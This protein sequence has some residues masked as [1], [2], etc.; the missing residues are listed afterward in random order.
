MKEIC[1]DA[2]MLDSGGIG[3]YLKRIILGLTSFRLRLLVFPDA[4]IKY[5]WLSPF[6]LLVAPFPIYSVQEQIRLP[7]LIPSCDIFWSPHFNIPLL[8][9]RAKKRVVTIHDV[10]HLAFAPT[11]KPWERVYAKTVIQRAVSCSHVVITIS[12]FSKQ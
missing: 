2:R 4:I 7:F 11:F 12:E 1:L 6:E 10:Y 9:I 5:P 3:V 8:P